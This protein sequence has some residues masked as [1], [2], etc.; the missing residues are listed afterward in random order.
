MFFNIYY[1][2]EENVETKTKIIFN[3]Y[4]KKF[5]KTLTTFIRMKNRRKFFYKFNNVKTILL[6]Y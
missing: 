3:D 2:I 4:M 6:M 5:N 1:L